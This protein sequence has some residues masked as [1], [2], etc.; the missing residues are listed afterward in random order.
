[1]SPALAELAGWIVAMAFVLALLGAVLISIRR[2]P[3]AEDAIP[4]RELAACLLL[5]LFVGMVCFV[6]PFACRV[7]AGD[8][9]ISL[10]KEHG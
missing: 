6:A 2:N 1:M 3:E 8:H 7:M 4:W 9:S 10:I 5:V